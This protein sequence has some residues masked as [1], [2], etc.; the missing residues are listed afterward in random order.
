MWEGDIESCR[1][2][3]ILADVTTRRIY[4][5]GCAISVDMPHSSGMATLLLINHSFQ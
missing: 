5:D 2:G 1:L 4:G 3:Q